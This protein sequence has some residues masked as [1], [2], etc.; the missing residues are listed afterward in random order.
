MDKMELVRLEMEKIIADGNGETFQAED[1]VEYAKENPKSVIREEFDK[2]NL[3]NDSEAARQ[4]RLHFAR[5]LIQ[6]VKVKFISSSEAPVSLRV[7]LNLREERNTPN[8]GYR[9]R[10]QV[11][12]DP[13]RKQMFRKDF[14]SDIEMLIKRYIDILPPEQVKILRSVAVQAA[15]MTQDDLGS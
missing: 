13:V 5:Q 3:F 6:R 7:Y 11:M 15:Q 1:V 10:S 14:G 12:T 2:Q 9:S 8:R 4:G